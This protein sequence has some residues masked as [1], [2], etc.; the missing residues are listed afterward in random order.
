MKLGATIT[1]ERG[2]AVTKTGNEFIEVILNDEQNNTIGRLT[3]R[4]QPLNGSLQTHDNIEIL[5]SGSKNG[6]YQVLKDI[7]VLKKNN[8]NLKH[9]KETMEC[10]QCGEQIPVTRSHTGKIVPEDCPFCK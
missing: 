5:F 9:G 8:G 10:E 6:N 1:S 7:P 4:Y 2:K 3:M